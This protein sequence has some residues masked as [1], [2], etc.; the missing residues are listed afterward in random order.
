MTLW[1]NTSFR[2]LRFSTQHPHGV[3]LASVIPLLREPMT[4]F[5]LPG[6]QAHTLYTYA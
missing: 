4:S 6:H 5:E 1:L 3:S 2:E